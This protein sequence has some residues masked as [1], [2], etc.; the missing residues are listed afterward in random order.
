MLNRIT[1][2]GFAL[3]APDDPPA[4][5]PPAD[6]PTDPPADPPKD[7]KDD[8]D[9]AFAEM[10]RQLRAA[11]KAKADAEAKVAERDRKDAE[12]Q[13]KWKELAEAAEAKAADLEKRIADGERRTRVGDAAARLDFVDPGDAHR[14]L[15][16]DDMEDDRSV[17]AALKRLAKDKPYL[18]KTVPKRTGREVGDRNGADPKEDPADQAGQDILGI[19]RSGGLVN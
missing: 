19:L 9:A 14:F 1:T 10:R 5:G 13:G 12:A 17:E 15:D 16:A 4:G 8:R 18:I 6:P 2:R 11:E 3:L 7:T